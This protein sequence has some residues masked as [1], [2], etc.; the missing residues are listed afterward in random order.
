MMRYYRMLKPYLLVGL[1]YL[2]VVWLYDRNPKGLPH[3]MVGVPVMVGLYVYTKVVEELQARQRGIELHITVDY[4]APKYLSAHPYFKPAHEAAVKVR[5][6]LKT[7]GRSDT[8]DRL[9]STGVG[10]SFRFVYHGGLVWSEP[11]KTFVSRAFVAGRVLGDVL[12]PV[13]GDAADIE[14]SLMVVESRGVVGVLLVPVQPDEAFAG[15]RREK[16]EMRAFNVFEEQKRDELLNR[17]PK[18]REPGSYDYEYK[19]PGEPPAVVL[20]QFPVHAFRRLLALGENNSA[21]SQGEFDKTWDALEK[22]YG[23]SAPKRDPEFDP[24]DRF[25]LQSEWVRFTFEQTGG[26]VT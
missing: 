18:V 11:R 1:L 23:L 24:L 17:T 21:I 13:D 14:P 5:E 6:K 20:G 7:E 2:G 26:H 15:T 25:E 3:L 8:Y 19:G 16:S 12:G 10:T 22:R 9:L 4:S